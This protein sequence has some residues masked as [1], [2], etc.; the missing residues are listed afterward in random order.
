MASSSSF[1]SVCLLLASKTILYDLT[2]WLYYRKT[3][4]VGNNREIQSQG[5]EFHWFK[6]KTFKHTKK[7]KTHTKTTLLYFIHL[8]AFCNRYHN[9]GCSRKMGH[10]NSL[11]FFFPIPPSYSYIPNFTAPKIVATNI[12]L[13]SSIPAA[14]IQCDI[15]WNQT[16]NN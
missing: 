13:W 5:K 6:A 16:E 12:G 4:H 15:T 7:K 10:W 2:N 8:H 9:S 1:A 14:H 11:L 3:I